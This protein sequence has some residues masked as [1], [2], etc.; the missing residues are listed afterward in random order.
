MGKKAQPNLIVARLVRYFPHFRDAKYKITSKATDQ[1]NCLAWAMGDVTRRWDSPPV[2]YWP[3]GIPPDWTLSNILAVLGTAG[4]A[5]CL[6]FQHES[7]YEKIAIYAD[8]GTGNITHFARLLRNGHW[9][10]KL[11]DL[12]DIQHEVLGQL[13]CA[14]YGTAV[15]F[16]KRR[17]SWLRRLLSDFVLRVATRLHDLR[18]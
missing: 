8:Q 14:E 1:Y 5:Q 11:G 12:E 4:Y 18:R 7:G 17:R 9:T 10:S 13:D 15:Y 2:Y 3:P 6:S 16:V